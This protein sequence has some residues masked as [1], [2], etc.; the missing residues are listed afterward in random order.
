MREFLFLVLESR[1]VLQPPL[2]FDASGPLQPEE[3]QAA[4]DRLGESLTEERQACVRA[5]LEQS[6]SAAGDPETLD[7]ETIE[8][9]PATNWRLLDEFGRRL[10]LAQALTTQA[11]FD[12]AGE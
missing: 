4:I 9:L 8:L 2:V 11:L 3:L 5:E 7:P 6:A 1:P 12:C 10:I